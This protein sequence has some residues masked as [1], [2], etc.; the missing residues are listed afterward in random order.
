MPQ[1]RNGMNSF[2]AFSQ[3]RIPA[4]YC[5]PQFRSALPGRRRPQ[6]RSAPCRRAE[7]VADHVH[8]EVCAMARGQAFAAPRTI[9]GVRVQA[10]PPWPPATPTAAAPTSGASRATVPKHP[11]RPRRQWATGPLRT[12]ETQ[13]DLIC[14]LIRLPV[15]GPGDNQNDGPRAVCAA[16]QACRS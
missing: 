9:G 2:Q 3:S 5:F 11:A 10:A 15:P 8:D 16:C 1:S 13:N 12:R 14:L 4:P 7:D 6:R